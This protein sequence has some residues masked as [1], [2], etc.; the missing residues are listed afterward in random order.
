[1]TTDNSLHRVHVLL[2]DAPTAALPELVRHIITRARS[3]GLTPVAPPRVLVTLAFE[4]GPSSKSAMM[5]LTNALYFEGVPVS[6]LG[7]LSD[8]GSYSAEEYLKNGR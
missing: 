2:E 8:L 7:E 5:D 1:M 3:Y 4:G 6:N